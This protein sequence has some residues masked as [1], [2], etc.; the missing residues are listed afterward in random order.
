LSRLLHGL[1]TKRTRFS[2]ALGIAL[3]GGTLAFSSVA[4][5]DDILQEGIT[6]HRCQPDPGGRQTA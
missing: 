4:S 2:H 1:K 6:G 3:I 5:A